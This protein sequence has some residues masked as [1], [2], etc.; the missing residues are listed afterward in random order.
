[1]QYNPGSI[2]KRSSWKALII[3]VLLIALVAAIITGYFVFFP[4]KPPPD[5]YMNTEYGLSAQVLRYLHWS[6]VNGQVD[7]YWSVAEVKSVGAKPIY[8]V[9]AIKGSHS[10]NIFNLM[11][12][13][14]D[15][16]SGPSTAILN[17]NILTLQTPAFD[18]T[19]DSLTFRG[20]SFKE[21]SQELD[22]FK[23]T[24]G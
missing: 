11:F 21:Y 17:G 5:G 19:V 1:M 22:D 13:Y 15:G 4:T 9:G 7:G 3:I 12:Y 18:G 6:E 14:P 8:Q 16:S 24:Y 20:V 23:A 2:P 10:G